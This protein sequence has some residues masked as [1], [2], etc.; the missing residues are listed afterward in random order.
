MPA[1]DMPTS[2]TV[3]PAGADAAYGD[4]L[5]RFAAR[6]VTSAGWRGAVEAY[7]AARRMPYFSGPDRTP[8]AALRTGR[9]A[10]TAKHLVLRDLLRRIGVA[11]DV[12]LVACDFASGVPVVPSMPAPLRGMVE[13][14]GIRD[15]HCWVRATG[16]GGTHR[17]DATWPDELAACGFPVN[18][19]WDGVGDTRPAVEGGVVLDTAEDVIRRKQELLA[20]LTDAESA[21]RRVFLDHLSAWL[22][23]LPEPKGGRTE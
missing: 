13:R 20:E 23:H 8:L 15:V 6:H 10:C 4:A 14:A 16:E 19:D 22:A 18:R 17:L 7:H 3:A 11:A 9:G 21:E 1:T 12:E 5:D 2:E